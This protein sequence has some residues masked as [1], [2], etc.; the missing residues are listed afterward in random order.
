MGH[1]KLA[2]GSFLP[3]GGRASQVWPDSSWTW[4]NPMPGGGVGIRIRC[5]LSQTFDLP[6]RMLRFAFQRLIAVG[7]VE[8]E[9]GGTHGLRGY[10]SPKDPNKPVAEFFGLLSAPRACRMSGT[11]PD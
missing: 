6:T 8:L 3:F 5:G 10:C 9:F 1:G 11:N 7:T 4:V 2:I